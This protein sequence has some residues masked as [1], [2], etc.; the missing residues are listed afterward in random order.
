LSFNKISKYNIRKTPKP[1]K[2]L[3]KNSELDQMAIKNKK[4]IISCLNRI[5]HKKI[6][7]IFNKIYV[8]KKKINAITNKIVVII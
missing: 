8:T 7:N 1:T 5:F 6:N 4:I 2:K 3:V